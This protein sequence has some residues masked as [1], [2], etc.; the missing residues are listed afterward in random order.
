MNLKTKMERLLSQSWELT[1]RQLVRRVPYQ[2][3]GILFLNILTAITY[4]TRQVVI[5]VSILIYG[6]GGYVIWAGSQTPRGAYAYRDG[7]SQRR[8]GFGVARDYQYLLNK[9][10]KNHLFQNDFYYQKRARNDTLFR[11]GVTL[12]NGSQNECKK[13]YRGKAKDCEDSLD[14]E[15]LKNIQNSALKY[16]K[17]TSIPF[18]DLG[19]GE[20]FI[21]DHAEDV[22]FC[23]DQKSWYVWSDAY[24]VVSEQRVRQLAKQTTR[25]IPAE[26]VSSPEMVQKI[27]T[28][29]KSSEAMPRQNAMLE[30]ASFDPKIAQPFSIFTKDTNLFNL[31]NGTYDLRTNP[32]TTRK[33]RSYHS[34]CQ[35]FF[36][37][38]S[39]MQSLVRVHRGSN[40]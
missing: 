23:S 24:W 21:N 33:D 39:K 11:E 40:Q 17:S 8:L 7:Y 25:N 26:V 30:A 37:Q 35:R 22:I 27:I 14:T 2:V 3:V 6:E 10:G 12:V 36:T 18:T 1:I 32:A 20:R 16:R 13:S 29:Q 31:Q 38:G 19:N 5:S 15:E 34:H 4:E 9:E 28:W